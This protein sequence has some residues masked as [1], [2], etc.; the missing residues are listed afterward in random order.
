MGCSSAA[1]NIAWAAK[2]V[3]A[4]NANA[5][6]TMRDQVKGKEKGKKGK[7]KKESGREALMSAWCMQ[8]VSK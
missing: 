2:V 5:R 8:G 6:L 7:R 3:V 1:T 4:V